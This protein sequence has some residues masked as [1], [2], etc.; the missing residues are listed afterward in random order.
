MRKK[1]KSCMVTAILLTA[2]LA[3]SSC[4]NMYDPDAEYDLI[5]SLSEE[6][7][8][9][10]SSLQESHS[11]E[12]MSSSSD[13]PSESQE[14]FSS[15]ESS[16]ES[17]PDW[18]ELIESIYE[19]MSESR[20]AEYSGEVPS[21]L[22][23]TES[24]SATVDGFDFNAYDGYHVP[25]NWKTL[26]PYG[27]VGR[28]NGRI[29]V[30]SVFASEGEHVWDFE[31]SD[32]FQAY[33]RD[34]YALK[35]ACDFLETEC[36][37]YGKDVEFIWDW[38]A[39]D[40][41]YYT[42]TMEADFTDILAGN[43]PISQEAW[44][45]IDD[46]INSEGIRKLYNADSVIYLFFLNS[47]EDNKQPSC[48]RDFYDGMPYPYEICYIQARNSQGLTV[49]AILAHEMLHAFGAPDLYWT[50]TYSVFELDY[51]I[52]KEYTDT[53]KENGLN[54]IMRI[55]WDP[56]TGQYLTKKI[57]QHIT[58]ITAY[59]TGLID[60]SETVQQWGFDPSDFEQR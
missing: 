7:R 44:K 38:M 12:S 51:G 25:K 11:V 52:T 29:V 15:E 14:F 60:Q 39:N 32:D 5:A 4:T 33:S 36:A 8:V 53:I 2:A 17:S 54:D 6:T 50:D 35:T 37:S 18:G 26:Y 10:E 42:T 49:P 47:P 16:E 21:E 22:P 34:Y 59:Y 27:S 40:H 57:V 48:T 1:Q 24:S 3:L 31:D 28:L 43:Y 56:K 13:T 45:Y 19:S 9:V 55:T 41:L 58:D 23:S 30:V 46:N 20:S